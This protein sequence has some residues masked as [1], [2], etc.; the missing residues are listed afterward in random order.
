MNNIF[1]NNRSGHTVLTTNERKGLQIKNITSMDELD[2]AEQMNIN[3]GLL[4]LQQNKSDILTDTFILKLHNKLFGEVWRWAGKYRHTEKNIGINPLKITSEVHKLLEDTKYWIENESFKWDELIAR[5]HHR[6]VYI[7][8]FS[9]GN[10]RFSRIF[11]N[12]LCL[13]NKKSPPS[14]KGSLAPAARR[15]LYIKALQQAD[16]KDYSALIEFLTPLN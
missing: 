8:P 13:K 5:N 11:T 4:W 7:H 12:E 9:N 3:E 1:F 2:Q 14:W 16:L 6:L 10:G 15:S